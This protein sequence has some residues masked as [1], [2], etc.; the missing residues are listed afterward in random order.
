MYL[1]NVRIVFN[2]SHN[3]IKTKKKKWILCVNRVTC[4]CQHEWVDASEG[5]YSNIQVEDGLVLSMLRRFTLNCAGLKPWR[6]V[7]WLGPGC[8]FCSLEVTLYWA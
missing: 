7:S 4:C 5:P 2:L 6:F 8:W 1:I 3:L